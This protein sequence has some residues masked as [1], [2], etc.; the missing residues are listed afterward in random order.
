M[1]KNITFSNYNIK[2]NNKYF[3]LIKQTQDITY[4][5]L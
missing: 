3:Y 1:S 4:T 5:I 2:Y